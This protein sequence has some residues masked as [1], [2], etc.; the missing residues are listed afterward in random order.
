MDPNATL[1]DILRAAQQYGQSGH[2]ADLD[3]II[4]KATA[5]REW[6]R[7]GGFRPDVHV[8]VM[9]DEQYIADVKAGWDDT[10]QVLD[11]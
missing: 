10:D 1:W 3:E 9:T 11:I 7:N 5:L 4:Q 6:A 2:M 8:V